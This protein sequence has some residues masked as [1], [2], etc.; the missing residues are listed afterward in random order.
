MQ[1]TRH[2]RR[3]G[4]SDGGIAFLLHALDEA[5]DKAAWHGTNLRGSLRGIGPKAA[6][7]RPRPG[8]HN[9]REIV[10]HAAYWKYLVRSRLTGAERGGFPIKGSNWFDL[11]PVTDRAWKNEREILDREHRALRRE[12]AAFPPSR[13]TRPLPKAKKRTALRE[14][15]GAALHD[16]YHTGQIQ[17][18]KALGGKATRR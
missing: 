1:R 18:L 15:V 13:L 16:A 11:G 17:L 6:D 14:I 10:V 4:S 8:R 9:I 12:V 5:Y 3:A 7:A 2:E